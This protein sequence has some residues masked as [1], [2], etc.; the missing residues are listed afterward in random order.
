MPVELYPLRFEPIFKNNLWGGSFLR[1]LFGLDAPSEP[2][3]EAWLLSDQGDN[4]SRV[5][6]GP[7]RGKTLR[8]L[9]GSHRRELIGSAAAP[10]DRFPLL[11]KLLD[12]RQPLSVQVHPNDEQ[13]Q[14]LESASAGFGKTEAWVILRTEPG[15]LL[16]AGLREGVTADEFREALKGGTLPEVLHAISPRPGD[17]FF[18]EAG[19]IHAIGAGLI[20]F[21]VQQTSDITYRLFDWG[22]VDAKTGRPRPL[23]IE[24]ALLCTN[25]EAGP[26]HAVK[27]A[28]LA[29]TDRERLVACQYFTLDRIHGDRRFP[30]GE[31]GQCRL[32]VCLDGR[33]NLIHKGKSHPL[34]LGDVLL[35]PAAISPCECIPDGMATVLEIWIP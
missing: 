26:C 13:A 12:A 23:H 22:R 21:E 35:L 5:V 2:E 9:M 32:V 10:L 1:P 18:L 8:D 20:L 16:Y 29:G 6:D 33:A 4:V 25:V 11:L 17:C 3:G 34:K 19:M 14:R 30:V 28:R 7:L 27:P 31:S 15:S 24:S